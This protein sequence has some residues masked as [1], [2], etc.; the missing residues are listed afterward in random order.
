[1]N[2]RTAIISLLV[3]TFVLVALV[4]T[5]QRRLIYFPAAL[6]PTAVPSGV[7]AVSYT[8]ED[9]VTLDA[10]YLAAADETHGTVI[11]F[12]G[13]AGNRAGRQPLGEALRVN[14][15][16]VLLTDYRGYGG[17]PGRPTEQGLAAD[18]RA[19]LAYVRGRSDTVPDAI[20]YF[21][22]SLG[23]AVAIG[24][25]HDDPPAALVL[26]SPF[27]SLIDIAGTHYPFLPAS[28]LLR[29]R[30]PNLDLIGAIDVPLLVVA[31]TLDQ[32]V[33]IDQS[34]RVLEAAAGF[35]RLLELPDADHNDAELA[36]G[37][38]MIAEVT[39]FLVGNVPR[40]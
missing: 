6:T 25:A 4:W 29:D 23:A 3:G 39:G 10:W 40:K 33:P 38:R 27:T 12:N 18:A 14:G 19:A 9:G 34:R 32:I 21:G 36:S 30:Y 35:A 13:N 24:L 7:E 16:S 28:I 1:M 11:V 15:F 31:G 22:E 37:D 26:R 17:N 8:T 20:F 5:F 2:V